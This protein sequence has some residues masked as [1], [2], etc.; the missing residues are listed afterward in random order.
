MTPLSDQ[1][2]VYIVGSLSVIEATNEEIE[3]LG[4]SNF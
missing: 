2:H 3:V 1:L 4:C